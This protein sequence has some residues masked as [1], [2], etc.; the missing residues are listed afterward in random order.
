M[1]VALHTEALVF[2]LIEAIQHVLKQHLINTELADKMDRI[3][4]NHLL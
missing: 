3:V 4:Q 1:T 2:N